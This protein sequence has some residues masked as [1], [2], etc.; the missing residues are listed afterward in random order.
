MTK[1]LDEKEIISIFS[2]ALGIADLDDVA[3]IDGSRN[4]VFK[5]DM[6]VASTDV[7]PQM[8]PW[9]VAR[10]SIVSCASDLAAKGARPVAAMISL[11]LPAGIT[12]TYV[13]ELA[14]GFQIASREFGVKIVGGDTNA[15][16]DL[17]ID[18]SMI[19]MMTMTVNDK[20]PKRS[21]AK[22]GDAVVASGKF[23]YPASGLAVLLRGARAQGAFRA[24]AVDSALEPKPRQAFGTALARYFSSS[25]DSSDGLAASLYEIAIQSGVDIKVDYDAARA[26]G[27]QE[28]AGANNLD[29][30]ELVFHGGEEYE[31]V[32]T[33]PKSLLP[34]AKAAAKKAGC[35]LH[36]I[37]CVIKGTGKVTAGERPLENRGYLHFS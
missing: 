2:Q 8:R 4:L 26:D 27:V 16:R 7:P 12:R 24:A 34:R 15:A 33:M 29:A 19:G 30:H 20:M 28:F 36:V 3:A 37:G 18:C 35:D 25:I 11:G 13:E 32:A 1:Q 22:P 17:V 14:R 21:G 10:K 6:L 23:G 9:Q 31:I 5:A